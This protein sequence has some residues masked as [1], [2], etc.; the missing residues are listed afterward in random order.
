[1]RD[2]IM[3]AIALSICML[4]ACSSAPKGN[5]GGAPPRVQRQTDQL[6]MSDCMGNGGNAEF[7]SDR[8]TN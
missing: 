6:C 8:C 1:M 4:G 7:C 3:I 2:P 5:D